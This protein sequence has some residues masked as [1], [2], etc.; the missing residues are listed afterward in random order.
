MRN[1]VRED[2]SEMIRSGLQSEE[3]DG[4]WEASGE[5]VGTVV[6]NLPSRTARSQNLRDRTQLPPREHGSP[7]HLRDL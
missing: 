4:D 2:A 6:S 5:R 1:E 7:P 3:L